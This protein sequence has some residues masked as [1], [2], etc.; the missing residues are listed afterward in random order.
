MSKYSLYSAEL[1]GPVDL[2]EADGGE[3]TTLDSEDSQ[4]AEG[5]LFLESKRT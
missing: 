3:R 1:P 2:Q 4:A 5:M